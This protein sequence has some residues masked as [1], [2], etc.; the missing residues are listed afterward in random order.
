MGHAP[1]LLGGAR[2]VLDRKITALHPA[3]ML[4]GGS[5]TESIILS[6]LVA[7]LREAGYRTKDVKRG[8]PDDVRS[9]CELGDCGIE[10]ILETEI[11]DEEVRRFLLLAFDFS[12]LVGLA[13][14][15]EAIKVWE[16]IYAVMDR[17]L[18]SQFNAESLALT[19]VEVAQTIRKTD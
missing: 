15:S 2:F 18:R 3:G 8:N 16:G 7:E 13:A 10:L 6:A 19:P 9:R 5:D 17:V 14:H 4:R 12:R 1:G 11:S